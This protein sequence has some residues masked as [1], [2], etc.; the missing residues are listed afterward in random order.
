MNIE[1]EQNENIMKRR[2][3]KKQNE[4]NEKYE[5][6]ARVTKKKTKKIELQKNTSALSHSRLVLCEILETLVWLNSS[7]KYYIVVKK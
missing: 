5:N 6:E 3:Q 2:W 4:H 1:S 7:H